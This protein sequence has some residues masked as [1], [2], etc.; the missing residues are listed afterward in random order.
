MSEKNQSLNNKNG[1]R[2]EFRVA[3]SDADPFLAMAFLLN[4]IG[5]AINNNKLLQDSQKIY[6]NAFDQ[7]Y[8]FKKLPQNLKIAEELFLK[9]LEED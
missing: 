4:A 9:K 1:A 8:S 7:Q 6:G 5:D 2:V 3:A